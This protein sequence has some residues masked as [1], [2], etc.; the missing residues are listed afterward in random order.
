MI[1]I[2]TL[3]GTLLVVDEQ[4]QNEGFEHGEQFAEQI[5]VMIQRIKEFTESTSTSA[6]NIYSSTA[7]QLESMEEIISS[8]HK[9]YQMAEDS[10]ELIK[11]FQVNENKK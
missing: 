9:L 11:R 10:K 7:E 2:I 3:D 4:L 6:Q 5:S 1:H 8:I